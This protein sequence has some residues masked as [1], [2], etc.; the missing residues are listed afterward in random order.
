ML[1]GFHLYSSW[2]SEIPLVSDS[3]ERGGSLTGQIE[4]AGK[5]SRVSHATVLRY[6]SEEYSMMICTVWKVSETWSMDEHKEQ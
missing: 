3:V 6:R 2:P 5:C 4:V 1:L